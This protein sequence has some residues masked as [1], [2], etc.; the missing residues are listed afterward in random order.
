MRN[1]P[2]TETTGRLAEV[3]SSFNKPEH[4]FPHFVPP[5]FSSRQVQPAQGSRA[6]H[7]ELLILLS[8]QPLQA[9]PKVWG[10]LGPGC[11]Q[12]SKSL[13]GSLRE[14]EITGHWALFKGDP[15]VPCGCVVALSTG[16][17]LVVPWG[18]QAPVIPAPC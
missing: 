4:L 1:R 10:H 12:L 5:S 16:G 8:P 17:H 3:P 13:L 2:D 18:Q 11:Q 6:L 7:L 14:V 15:A 9:P